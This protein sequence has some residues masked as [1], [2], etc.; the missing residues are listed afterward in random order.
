MI[1]A[2]IVREVLR[3]SLRVYFVALRL[4]A[5][6]G[7]RPAPWGH[8][9]A[10][11]LLTLNFHAPG[12]PR[13]LLGPLARSSRLGSLRIV[14]TA[15]A[16]GL[17]GVV[18]IRPPR[19]L[20]GVCGSTLARLA[21][22]AV[23]AVRTRPM[24]VGGVHLLFNGLA[25]SLVAR[26]AGARALYICVGGP[27]EVAG[28]GIL[29]E[30]RAFSLLPRAD[31]TIERLLLTAVSSFDYVVTMGTRAAAFFRTHGIEAPAF[32]VP[33]GVDDTQFPAGGA[34]RDIDVIVVARLTPVK[35]IDLFVETI[36]KVAD[37]RPSVRAVI[38][39]RGPQREPAEALARRLGVAD[40]IAFLG[41]EP[42]VAAWLRRA[43]VFLL[44]SD[45]EGVSIS[46]IEAMLSGAVPVVS[47]VGDLADVVTTN[48]SGML[49]TGRT[50]DAFAGPIAD[51]LERPER[52]AVMSASARQAAER[53][54][55]DAIAQ[56]WDAVLCE[57]H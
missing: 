11:V 5:W 48:V 36:R 56:R 2:T 14:A 3:A 15:D 17:E 27:N 39:G 32:V 28:G 29:S 38:I 13:A 44:T 42:D 30:N 57:R 8:A 18:V 10:D 51:L 7:P 37:V 6:I 25:A 9:P 49:V 53:F 54:G 55:P 22:F 19:W 4:A 40:R 52:W 1:A 33:S 50:G 41:Y 31:A 43:R 26:L 34:D 23:V 46:L 35:R 16:P 24:V 21:T 47:D 12:W 20:V 45:T